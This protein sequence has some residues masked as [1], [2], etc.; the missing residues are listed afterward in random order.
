MH[1]FTGGA[2]LDCVGV[3][4]TGGALGE[5]SEVAIHGI[6]VE[7]DQQI[8]PVTHIR[9]FFWAGANGEKG[10][11][12]ANDRLIS[13]VGVQV[14]P[15][16][17]EDLCE[18]VARRGHTLTCGASDADSKGLPHSAISQSRA[19]QPRRAPALLAAC[20]RLLIT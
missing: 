16:A 20:C 17:T 19:T 12:T 9:D 6:L 10:V 7:R 8:E 13:V 3:I 1:A 14:Q 4:N 18:D 11:A 2:W 5:Q 15:A